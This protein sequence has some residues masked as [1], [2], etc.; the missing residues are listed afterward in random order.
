MLKSLVEN[1]EKSSINVLTY[2][3]RAHLL[4]QSFIKKRSIEVIEI[5][6]AS[7]IEIIKTIKKSDAII[8]GGGTCF[9]DEGGTGGIKYML[10]AKLLGCKVYYAGIGADSHNRPSTKICMLVATIISNSIY[11]RDHDSIKALTKINPF[12]AKKIIKIHDL[13]YASNIAT[14]SDNKDKDIDIDIDIDIDKDKDKYIVFCPRN[15]VHYKNLPSDSSRKLLEVAKRVAEELGLRKIIVLNADPVVD[16]TV[17]EQAANYFQSVGFANEIVN[18][19]DLEKCS[20]SIQNCEFLLTIR[21]HPAVIALEN[22]IPFAIFNYSEK[23]R[24]FAEESGTLE[25]LIHQ[26]GI[27]NFKPLYTLAQRTHNRCI[28][29][30][31]IQTIKNLA[32]GFK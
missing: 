12:A 13:A 10:I 20:Y 23:N 7:K 9:M 11:A 16:Q 22:S 6:T 21:L 19:D 29:T 8:W 15:L 31:T 28:R 4:G 30:E 1:L 17:S 2:G 24:K 25:R 26:E 27:D 18:G 5:N 32:L 14:S 3:N